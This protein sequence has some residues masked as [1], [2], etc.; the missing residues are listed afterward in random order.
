MKKILEAELISLAHRV[1]KLK[2]RSETIQLQ[3]ETQKLYEQLT[4]LR[5]F[6]EN[7]QRLNGEIQQE[8][9]IAA[10]E[11][12]TIHA[13]KETATKVETV[14][15]VE[16]SPEPVLKEV[17]A[18]EPIVQVQEEELE[19]E[20]LIEQEEVQTQEEVIAE[21]GEIE[22]N[23]VVTPQEEVQYQDMF[24]ADFEDLDFVK[25]EDIAPETIAATGLL[26]DA[27]EVNPEKPKTETVAQPEAE[28]APKSINDKFNKGI[29]IGLNDRIAFEKRLFNGS[30]D[31]FNRVLSQLNS[32][33]SYQEVH[34][35]IND[36]VKPDYNNWNGLEEY[37]TRFLEIV[38]KKFN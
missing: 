2:N 12:H 28:K 3:Q 31:D 20:E 18:E 30:A 1:L 9:F 29:N 15:E 10:V 33:E 5:F 17:I 19:N 8:A 24:A 32:L 6:E 11:S 7:E 25:V 26:F 23:P 16:K 35:F 4:M 27:V 14:V 21:K 13:E 36:F 37:E 22:D 34:S 38:E